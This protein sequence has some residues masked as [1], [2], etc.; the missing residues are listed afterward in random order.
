[1]FFYSLNIASFGKE[2]ICEDKFQQINIYL[3]LIGNVSMDL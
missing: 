1:M 2:L 3:S